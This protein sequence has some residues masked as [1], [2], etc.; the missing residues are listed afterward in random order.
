MKKSKYFHRNAVVEIR[1]RIGQTLFKIE[2]F[3]DYWF[4]LTDN[5]QEIRPTKMNFS[6]SNVEIGQ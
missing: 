5:V 1:V 4:L 6:R 3:V 2:K